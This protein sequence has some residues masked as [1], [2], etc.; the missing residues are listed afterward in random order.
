MAEGSDVQL[1]Y[2]QNINYVNVY[3]VTAPVHVTPMMNE[4]NNH[5]KVH[6][7]SLMLDIKRCLIIQREWKEL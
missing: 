6:V 2:Y 7:H 5:T 3:I 4:I 1:L